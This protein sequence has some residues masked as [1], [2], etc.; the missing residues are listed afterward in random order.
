VETVQHTHTSQ[1]T[2]SSSSSVYSWRIDHSYSDT[3][4]SPRKL[5]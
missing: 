3:A 4:L 5:K 2:S 1:F